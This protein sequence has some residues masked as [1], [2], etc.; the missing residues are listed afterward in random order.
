MINMGKLIRQS[1]TTVVDISSF[2]MANMSWSALPTKAEFVI[3]EDHFAQGGFRKAN[4]ATS[5]TQG[6]SDTTWVI[7]KYLPESVADITAS[8]QDLEGHTKKV[9]QMHM[10]AKN[11]RAISF[12]SEKGEACKFWRVFQ[13]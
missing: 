2:D 8:G 10:L 1:K 7:K 13:L 3:A 11:C 12:S 4:K 5:Q 9:V 6:F